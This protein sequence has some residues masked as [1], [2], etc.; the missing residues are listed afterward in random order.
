ME[1]ISPKVREL[2]NMF[3]PHPTSLECEFHCWYIHEVEGAG[4]TFYGLSS[5]PAT[6]SH[7]LPSEILSTPL[8]EKQL[9]GCI[10]PQHD[11]TL[12]TVSAPRYTNV[13]AGVVPRISHVPWRDTVTEFLSDAPLRTWSFSRSFVFHVRMRK[14]V[15]NVT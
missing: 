12:V 8:G 15:G 9:R 14:G 1:E 4:K 10:S 5:L 6:L 11:D 7:T 13:R 3:L 2:G